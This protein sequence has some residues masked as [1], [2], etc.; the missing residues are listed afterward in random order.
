MV[1][2]YY[3][4]LYTLHTNQY[5]QQHHVFVPLQ[6]RL[7]GSKY[8]GHPTQKIN[9]CSHAFRTVSDVL[10]CACWHGQYPLLWQGRNSATLNHRT[11]QDGPG[12]LRGRFKRFSEALSSFPGSPG[13]KNRFFQSHSTPCGKPQTKIQTPP[14]L[15]SSLLLLLFLAVPTVQFR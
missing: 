5:S 8:R 3:L 10:R 13:N 12:G 14:P 7:S 6:Y 11:L 1:I 4:T 9:L 15:S 2:T